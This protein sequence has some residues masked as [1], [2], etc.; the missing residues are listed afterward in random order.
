MAKP[1]TK[2]TLFPDASNG[3]TS[4]L[5]PT[6]NVDEVVESV[7]TGT[8]IVHH[9][10][11]TPTDQAPSGEHPNAPDVTTAPQQQPTDNGNGNGNAIAPQPQQQQPP[12]LTAK[13]EPL[14]FEPRNVDELWRLCQYFANNDLVPKALR[15]KPGNCFVVAM[16]GREFGW[17][18]IQSIGSLN[19]IDGK[20]E[21]G[22]TAMVA[23]IRKSG[24]CRKWKVIETNAR[25]AIVETLRAGDEESFVYEYTIEEAE[26]AGL[27]GKDNWRKSPRDMLLRRCESKVGR[28]V[29]P[30]VAGA[31]YDHGEIEEMRERERALGVDSDRII[32]ID[33]TSPGER[34]T[35]AAHPADPLKERLAKKAVAHA[36]SAAGGL[37][38]RCS[39]CQTPLD[40]RDSDPCIACRPDPVAA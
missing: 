18:T 20:V 38:R 26:T 15:G 24:L 27:T 3:S 30:D 7:R 2:P 17:S 25:R 6:V 8:P 12:P 35:V 14:P 19:I 31:Y 34:D 37:V 13:K 40:P 21:I 1:P 23:Q 11:L 29:Y 32:N 36:A 16:K 9:E 39:E 10:L 28:I 22:A 4:S 5:L 33:D